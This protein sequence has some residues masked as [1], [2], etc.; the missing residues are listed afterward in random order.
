MR[1]CWIAGVLHGVIGSAILFG[2]LH[3][4]RDM[5]DAHALELSR[6]GS[7]TQIA[8][9]LALLVLSRIPS[10]QIPA[11][12]IAVGTTAWTAILYVI[13]FTGQHPLDLGVPGGGAIMLLGWIALLFVNPRSTT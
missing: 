7:A 1:W 2:T 3:P 6:V 11:A 12:L 10:T 5:L 13:V 9:G 4:L 8:Q